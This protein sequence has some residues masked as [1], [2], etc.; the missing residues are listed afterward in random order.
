M[1][2][3]SDDEMQSDEGNVKKE[4]CADEVK[5]KKT[6][7]FQ[8]E[9]ASEDISTLNLNMEIFRTI[10]LLYFDNCNGRKV[11]SLDIVFPTGLPRKTMKFQWTY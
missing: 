7:E 11:R 2:V 4:V 10:Q 6:S 9:N 3:D 1:D 8:R 5:K